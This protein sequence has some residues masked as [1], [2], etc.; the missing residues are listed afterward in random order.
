M[1]NSDYE[2]FT[3]IDDQEQEQLS[4]IPTELSLTPPEF[5]PTWVHALLQD[6]KKKNETIDNLESKI[7]EQQDTLDEQKKQIEIQETENQKKT[8]KIKNL[9]E[10]LIHYKEN[11]YWLTSLVQTVNTIKNWVLNND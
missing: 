7:L 1:E 6:I 5:S 2:E 8:E 3:L 10:K 11:E 4:D 9:N